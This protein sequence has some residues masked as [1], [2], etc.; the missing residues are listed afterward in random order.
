V[1]LAVDGRRVF[2]ATGGRV[3]D[4]SLP[5]V[6]FLHGAGM[7][8]SVWAL[9]ARHFAHAGRAVL[10]PD[11]PGHG[12][13]DGPPQGTIEEVAGWLRRLLDAAGVARAALVGH[14][15][16]SLVALAAAAADPARTTALVL[17]ATAVPMRVVAE[18]LAAARDDPG[19]AH[20]MILDWGFGPRAAMGG[21]PAP[22]LWRL[23]AALR[24]LERAGP[25]VLATDLAACAAYERGL[26]DARAVRCRTLLLLGARDRMTPPRTA[27]DLAE[28]LFDSRT[29]LLEDCG[30]MAM[31]E[32]PDA[33]LDALRAALGESFGR[34]ERI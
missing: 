11:L 33:V 16:G 17:I 18:L 14:S 32:Q 9:P 26:Q 12:R 15:M 29:V 27:A 28:A 3:F 6:V 24:L 4:P 25:G 5:A 10:A 8:H 21:N 30:H 22:G 2:A 19:R 20:R 34:P 23:G 31:A 13:S 1:E 7:D